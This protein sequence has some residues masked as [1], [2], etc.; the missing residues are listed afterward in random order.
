MELDEATKIIRLRSRPEEQGAITRLGDALQAIDGRGNEE[1]FRGVIRIVIPDN[2]GLPR[3]VIGRDDEFAGRRTE[4]P[5]LNHTDG[6]SRKAESR[7]RLRRHLVQDQLGIRKDAD[8]PTTGRN[9]R[10]AR[11]RHAH[12]EARG[13]GDIDGRRARR[14][15]PARQRRRG[16]ARP[17]SL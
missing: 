2:E 8:N 1:L 12:Q 15:R 6:A 10:T 16:G 17:E 9:P 5:A 14:S 13:A 3:G 7:I 11:N 4:R